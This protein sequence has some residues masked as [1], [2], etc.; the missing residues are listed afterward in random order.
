[1]VKGHTINESF[2]FYL[3]VLKKQMHIDAPFMWDGNNDEEWLE[4][5]NL[6]IEKE[7]W[8]LRDNI[9]ILHIHVYTCVI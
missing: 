1:M 6:E 2:L 5:E 9:L 7:T 8:V 3:W 4:G